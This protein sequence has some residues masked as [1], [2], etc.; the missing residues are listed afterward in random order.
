M[1]SN[2]QSAL[3]SSSSSTSDS[4]QVR[5]PQDEI[6]ASWMRFSA[7][8][9]GIV[10]DTAF[11]MGKSALD[12]AF[13][14]QKT[15]V[16]TT[17]QVQQTIAQTT[18]S[19]SETV[20][21]TV[22]DTSRAALETTKTMAGLVE[23]LTQ[24][25]QP[26]MD[27]A[28]QMSHSTAKESQRLLEQTFEGAGRAV[29]FVGQQPWI[30]ELS[31]AFRLN[32]LVDLLD[33]VDVDKATDVV[34]QL[35]QKYPQESPSQIAHHLMVEKAVYAGGMGLV[36]SLVPG[37]AAALLAVD[38]AATTAIQTEMVYQIAAA[39]GLDLHDPA[40]RGE[41]LAIFGLALG[42]NQA[43]RAGLGLLRNVPLAG[44]VIGAST[45]ATMIYALGYGACRFYEA[46]LQ[47][48]PLDVL[49]EVVNDL[50]AESNQYLQDVAMT[51]QAIMD[52]ILVH[53][54]LA[55]YPDRNWEAILPNL[56]AL[57]LSPASLEAIATHIRSPQPLDALL[58]QLNR[59][60]ATPLLA[61]C[62]RIAQFNNN[63]S[64]EE[65]SILVQI[66]DRFNLDLTEIER[67]VEQ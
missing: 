19:M 33:R 56:A 34:R 27:W 24:M 10:E 4:I 47:D 1:D 63:S 28:T 39:Y 8:I 29:D 48:K 2:R 50:R 38:L 14:I 16:G 59:D 20:S 65:T 61:Q 18:S 36:S 41:V 53:V 62:Y 67:M 55:S 49:P 13:G 12:T 31:G 15:I 58:D 21:R 60:Y 7:G 46:K 17:T 45:N 54:I 30:R 44:A 26:V 22:T 9:G 66:A 3:E 23:M 43:L 25:S 32:W 64:P 37:E 11:Q 57:Q 35:Q 42:G 52:Q 40:R 51:Q 6:I 5:S